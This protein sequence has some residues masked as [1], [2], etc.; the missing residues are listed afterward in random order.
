MKAAG[1]DVRTDIV[2]YAITFNFPHIPHLPHNN[3]I[4]TKTKSC[5][6]LRVF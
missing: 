3:K 6:V 5:S 2:G 4:R 1:I